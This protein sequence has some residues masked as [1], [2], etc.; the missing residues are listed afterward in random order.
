[1]NIKQLK[2]DHPDVYQAAFDNGVASVNADVASATKAGADAERQR[3]AAILTHAESTGREAQAQALALK[4]DLAPEAAAEVL[5]VTPI[6]TAPAANTNAFA[7]H[8]A[9]L[10]NP[11]IGAD[12]S[13]QADQQT[14]ISHGWDIARARAAKLRGG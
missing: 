9:S 8:M 11:N 7:Q 6:V 3:I 5:A 2:A 10:G 1:M 13:D 12:Q 14:N 4:T